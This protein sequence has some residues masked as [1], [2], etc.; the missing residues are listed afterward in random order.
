MVFVVNAAGAVVGA[1]C[2][3]GSSAARAPPW[4]DSKH[5]LSLLGRLLRAGAKVPRCKT[6]LSNHLER[7]PLVATDH[8]RP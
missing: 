6:S 3:A 1:L 4:S 8:R 2:G 7:P 5:C